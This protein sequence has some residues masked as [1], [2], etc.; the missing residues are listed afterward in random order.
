MDIQK[1]GDYSLT[2]LL[3]GGLIEIAEMSG[4]YYLCR[5]MLNTVSVGDQT[6]R[7]PGLDQSYAFAWSQGIKESI[8]LILPNA[9]ASFS[10]YWGP[11]SV[12]SGPHYLGF[13]VLPLILGL[14]RRN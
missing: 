3:I 2:I 1:N 10:D 13:L 5:N 11:K 7:K 14:L 8:T 4:N 6:L 12:T 9:F